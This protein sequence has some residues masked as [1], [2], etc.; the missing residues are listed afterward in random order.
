[1]PICPYCQFQTVTRRQHLE[2]LK[3]IH[4]QVHQNSIIAS[5]EGHSRDQVRYLT[6]ATRSVFDAVAKQ[7]Q[8]SPQPCVP[9]QCRVPG[10]TMCFSYEDQWIPITDS[11]EAKYTCSRW[12][13]ESGCI[14]CSKHDIGPLRLYC[15]RGICRYP[16]PAPSTDDRI[17]DWGCRGRVDNVYCH[18]HIPVLCVETN[19]GIQPYVST[20]ITNQDDSTGRFDNTTK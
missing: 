17:I 4:D 2:H 10:F 18:G 14:D 11:M 20:V 1:M 5:R 7:R 9:S 6:T 8:D 15:R 12:T 16:H 19:D 13:C 3:T